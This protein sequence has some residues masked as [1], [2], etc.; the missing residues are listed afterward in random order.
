MVEERRPWASAGLAVAMFGSSFSR[1]MEPRGL[2]LV[3]V[4]GS[5]GLLVGEGWGWGRVEGG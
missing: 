1:H 2:Q 3:G 5:D 4:A